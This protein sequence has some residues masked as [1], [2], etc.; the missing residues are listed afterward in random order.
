MAILSILF[1]ILSCSVVHASLDQRELVGKEVFVK[2]N[3][4]FLNTP[5]KVFP[6]KIV[7]TEERSVCGQ[8]VEGFAIARGAKVIIALIK[9]QGSFMSVQMNA[10]K[11]G[12]YEILLSKSWRNNFEKSFR[13]IFSFGP[14]EDTSEVCNPINV[15]EL[16]Q[17]YGYPIY[18]C[19]KDGKTIFYYN[20]AL[21]GR[22]IHGF[23]DIWIEVVDGRI[24]GESG[25]I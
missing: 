15:E 1:I 6:G 4:I 22:E 21:L 7:F 25:L 24:V 17:C 9:K 16:I 13:E 23:H 12:T 10:G 8:T 5:P 18:H 2:H 20:Y 19:K 11:Y 3:L 14:V